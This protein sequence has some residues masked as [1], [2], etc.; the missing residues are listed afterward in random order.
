MHRRVVV[1]RQGTMWARQSCIVRLLV[2][3]APKS[4]N[5]LWSGGAHRPQP[6]TA[7]Q[8]ERASSLRACESV[9]SSTKLA[10]NLSLSRARSLSLSSDPP[11]S[12]RDRRIVRVSGR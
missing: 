4:L 10:V 9:G 3:R 1:R 7:V 8:V 2:L 11:S 6:R 5:R 12:S